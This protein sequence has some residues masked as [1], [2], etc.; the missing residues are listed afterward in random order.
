[1]PFTREARTHTRMSIGH[2]RHGEPMFSGWSAR[3]PTGY[4]QFHDGSTVDID[5]FTEI[6]NIVGESWA[7]N[8]YKSNFDGETIDR[9]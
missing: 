1:M 2:E 6:C 3:Y 5:G 8:Y 9:E 4:D 7:A